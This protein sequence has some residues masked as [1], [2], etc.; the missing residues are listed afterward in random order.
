MALRVLIGANR[1]LGAL[2]IRQANAC[3]KG[4]NSLLGAIRYLKGQRVFIRHI[5]FK[6]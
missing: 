4:A 2:C 1:I 5:R 6:Y 3:S